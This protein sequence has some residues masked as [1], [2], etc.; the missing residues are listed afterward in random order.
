M[1][2]ESIKDNITNSLLYVRAKIRSFNSHQ[3][4][5]NDEPDTN[6][7]NLVFEDNFNTFNTDTW[8][9]GQPWGLFH[10]KSLYQYYDERSVYIK[11]NDLI[12]AET[13][14]PKEFTLED[15]TVVSIP[16]SVGLVTSKES[17]GYGFYEFELTLPNGSGL[18]SAA[19]L[20][21]ANSWPPEIDVV[22][23][24][25]DN[26]GKYGQKLQT[27]MFFGSDSDVKMAQPRN[28]PVYNPLARLKM[29]CWWTES[30]IKIYYNGYLVRVITSN[31]TLKWFKDQRMIIVLNN[32]I[33]Q[34]YSMNI[35]DQTTEFKIHNVK[36]WEQK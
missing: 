6:K 10:P 18:W 12:L 1:K 8:R 27:N 26:N 11:D 28:N 16:Y 21:G 3:T 35:K 36:V 24:Y 14:L 5:G 2:K 31:D 7:M 20:T 23:A 25:S 22:E 34:E 15:G 32:A 9:V 29:S 4:N 19:W 30:F 33:R 17:F 13:Y